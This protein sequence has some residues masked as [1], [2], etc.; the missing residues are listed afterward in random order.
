MTTACPYLPG[1]EGPLQCATTVMV[2]ETVTRGFDHQRSL[3]PV[4]SATVPAS[5]GAGARRT[6]R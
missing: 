2:G 4:R 6:R 3:L 1:S 5:W